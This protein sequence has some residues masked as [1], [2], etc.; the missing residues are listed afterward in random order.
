M[1]SPSGLNVS[2][3][4][5]DQYGLPPLASKVYLTVP[6]VAQI[7]RVSVATV[8]RAIARRAVAAHKPSG[9]HGRTLIRAVDLMAFLARSRIGA[10]G[11]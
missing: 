10:I 2:A 6:E 9:R 1:N 11:E 5:Q 8:R 7:M 4:I 3:A